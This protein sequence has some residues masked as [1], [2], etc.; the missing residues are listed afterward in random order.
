MRFMHLL[1]LFLLLLIPVV[2][3]MYLLKQ[4]AVDQKVPSLF[5][6]NEMYRN[7]ESD[8][9]WEKLKKNKL[10]IIQIITILVLVFCLMSPYT[11]TENEVSSNVVLLIDNSG[12]MSTIMSNKRTRLDC[13]KNAA[14]EYVKTLSDDTA[15]TVIACSNKTTSLLSASLDKSAVMSAINSIDETTYAGDCSEGL[16]ICQ[17]L[18]SG[19]TTLYV[20]AFTDA[21]ISLGN[22]Y[23]TIYN[24]ATPVQNVSLDYIS[25]S[26]KKD[27]LT[28]LACV[29]NHGT[30]EASGDLNLYG[31][32][33]LLNVSSYSLPAG[34]STIV[35]F[36]NTSFNGKI[37]K[38]ELN[39]KDAL[40]HDNTAFCVNSAQNSGRV[41]LLTQRNIYLKK[42]IE[43]NTNI[44]LHETNDPETFS[45]KAAEGY[46]L[47]IIDGNEMLPSELPAE[48][49]LI[50]IHCDPGQFFKTSE[51]IE[52]IYLELEDSS[53][54]SG[55]S[56]YKFG[57]TKA[58]PVEQ[59][60][61]AKSFITTGSASAGFVGE[62]GGRKIGYIGF[63]LHSTDLPLDY[64]FP[65]LIWNL[66]SEL[67]N[68]D[69]L[70][71]SNIYCGET[72]RINPSSDDG[73][74]T[75][76]LPGGRSLDLPELPIIFKET[77]KPGAYILKK[78]AEKDEAFVVNFDTT[79]SRMVT[80]VSVAEKAGEKAVVI[81]A[82]TQAAKSYRPLI[83][84]G[85][86][87]ILTIEWI[88]YIR[89]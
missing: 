73:L 35:Y 23:G 88:V 70:A 16:S 17:G 80:S 59:P 48:G 54:T 2:I 31:D 76:I 81:D 33:V 34:E 55:I 51:E 83:I 27:K 63:D 64:R 58:M 66:I 47:Y 56:G 52:N 21:P 15:V 18:A 46:D 5:L 84:I 44:T 8:T 1:P 75:L 86:L 49:N 65:I 62:Y 19:N 22:L 68:S 29:T 71:S 25:S 60:I 43:L 87:L 72:V 26:Q 69:L 12:S 79:E 14:K 24:F 3:I 20:T 78:G 45:G 85:L 30:D 36:E 10:L 67:G 41:L 89:D 11:A 7:K 42:A 38:G 9:P 13:A 6:W 57:V 82:S 50:F 32:D 61:W 40:M 77:A 4:K 74:P 53:F 39:N 28:V 37:L